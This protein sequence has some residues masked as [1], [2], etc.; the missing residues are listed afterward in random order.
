[1][2]EV[3]ELAEQSKQITLGGKRRK[4]HKFEETVG[5]VTLELFRQILKEGRC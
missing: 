5:K 2:S 3:S 1:M 4:G